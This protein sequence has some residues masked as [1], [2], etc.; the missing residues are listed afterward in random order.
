[1]DARYLEAAAVLVALLAVVKLRALLRRVEH[2]NTALQIELAQIECDRSRTELAYRERLHDARSALA[3]LSGGISVLTRNASPERRDLRRMLIAEIDRL[4]SL[5]DANEPEPITDFELDKALEPVLLAH[6]LANED[7]RCELDPVVVRGRPHATA[8][9]LDNI[10]RNAHTHAPGATINIDMRTDDDAVVV[11]VGD[12]G[13]GIPRS[14]CAEVLRP[15]V[16]GSTAR[17]A[18]SGLGLHSAATA[19]AKQHGYL[20]IDRCRAGGT[21]V[22][23]SLPISSTGSARPGASTSMA[24]LTEAS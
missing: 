15:G 11:R 14:E 8:A 19:M 23:F 20:S 4:E 6:R 16:R 5:L 10:L 18:G 17:G 13:P 21:L 2:E 3:G 24:K 12:D 9:V 22:T 1:M 7:I